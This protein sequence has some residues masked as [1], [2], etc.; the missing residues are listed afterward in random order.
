MSPSLPYVL[1]LYYSRYGA[2]RALA[3]HMVAGVESLTGISARLRTVPSVSPTCEAVEPE[4][5]EEGAVYASL[6]DLRDCAGLALG[7]PTRFGNMASSL[8]HFL[9]GT[10][11][12]WMNGTL[13]DKPATAFTSTS[14]L[15]GGQETTLITM[16]MPLLH[17]GMVYAGLP[18]SETALFR[19]ASGG[20][21][22][23]TS[24]LAGSRSDNP[25][26]ENERQLAYAQG[27]RLARLAKALYSMRESS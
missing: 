8:K 2:T 14:S 25:I 24:H 17:Q 1:I 13:I 22:Y 27:R 21:P 10:A 4:I 19:T 23:G 5:P 3:E 16:L 11:E 6:D 12:L 20:T 18:Y 15:H 9:D 7:S 26:D